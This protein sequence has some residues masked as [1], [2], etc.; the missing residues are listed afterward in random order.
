VGEIGPPTILL[1]E[2]DFAQFNSGNE[3]LGEWLKKRALK[4][5]TSGASKTFVICDDSHAVIGYYALATGSVERVVAP[6]NF[7]RG[8]PDP[9]PVIVLGRLAIDQRYQGQQ[10]GG[11]L[12]KDA[13]QR[14]LNVSSQVGI[15]GLLVHAIS[16]EA[17]R[18]Y[19]RYGFFE[20]TFELMTLMISMK[21]LL[22]HL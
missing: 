20:S 2:H 15:R 7:A 18:F 8:M 19:L 11:F 6:G 3:T 21:T 22:S 16:E 9:I 14:A 4:N 10:L 13:M 12:L 17:K 5:Q 1:P